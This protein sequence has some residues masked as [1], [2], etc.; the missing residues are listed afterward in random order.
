M[1]S[2][3]PPPSTKIL[4]LPRCHAD[5]SCHLDNPRPEPVPGS[6]LSCCWHLY[7]A[8]NSRSQA[9]S[10]G[11]VQPLKLP[12]QGDLRGELFAPAPQV[13]PSSSNLACQD[14]ATEGQVS[15]QLRAKVQPVRG[16]WRVG[17]AMRIEAHLTV[18]CW[19]RAVAVQIVGA[20]ARKSKCR[21]P[22]SLTQPAQVS[23]PAPG[24]TRH[25]HSSSSLEAS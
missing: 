1:G 4:Q 19:S 3:C 13:R 25:L 24:M 22:P 21:L 2:P 16:R 20:I 5:P 14:G 6:R 9:P 10:P 15:P 11:C 23:K 7:P 18:S 8:G 12:A 17:L